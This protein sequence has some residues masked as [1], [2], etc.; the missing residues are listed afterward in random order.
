MHYT[1]FAVVNTIMAAR[2]N[3]NTFSSFL[4]K[5]LDL[6]CILDAVSL[7]MYEF[8]AHPT[9]FSIRLVLDMSAL[10]EGML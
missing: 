10:H 9:M 2:V 5:V 7:K 1:S 8:Q 6:N 4:Y 3:L